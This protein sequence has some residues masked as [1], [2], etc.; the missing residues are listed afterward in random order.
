MECI[1][2]C[3]SKRFRFNKTCV[4]VCP[5]NTY[6]FNNSKCVFECPFSQPFGLTSGNWRCISSCK[7]YELFKTGRCIFDTEC[8]EPYFAFEKT[9][10]KSCPE[11]YYWFNGCFKRWREYPETVTIVLSSILTVLVVWSRTA[12]IEHFIVLSMI[13]FKTDARCTIDSA[14]SDEEGFENQNEDEQPLLI[15]LDENEET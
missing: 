15:E 7:S 1:E 4:P 12:L 11:G 10:I 2:N 6:N 13:L 14:E 3:P 5:K 8:K 9:C